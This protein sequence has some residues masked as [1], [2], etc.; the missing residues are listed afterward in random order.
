[1][2][3]GTLLM[4]QKSVSLFSPSQGTDVVSISLLLC[5]QAGFLSVGHW[6]SERFE[7]RRRAGH[8]TCRGGAALGCHLVVLLALLGACAQ[9]GALHVLTLRLPTHTAQQ[10]ALV[11]ICGGRDAHARADTN[12]V[13]TPALMSVIT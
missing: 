6:E 9:E 7:L 10:L 12:S 13:S 4:W 2:H 11:H 8:L 5:V 1:M 3:F